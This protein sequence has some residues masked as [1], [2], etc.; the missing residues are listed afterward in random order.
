M[1]RRH[2][3]SDEVW[4]LLESHLSGGRADRVAEQRITGYLLMRYY[5]SCAPVLPGAIC[6]LSMAAG[7]TRIAS[8]AAGI[9]W[10]NGRDC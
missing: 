10:A 1:S 5:G 4:M 8:S 2:D 7:R 3:I 6:S 9:I